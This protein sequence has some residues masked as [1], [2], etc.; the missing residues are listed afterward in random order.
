VIHDRAFFDAIPD[1]VAKR[2]HEIVPHGRYLEILSSCDLAILPL[3]DTSFNR[4]KSDLKFI[5]SCACG[6][7]PLCSPVVYADTPKHREIG[8]F[9]ES[10]QD[11][12]SALLDLCHYPE[13]LE[14][15]RSKALDYVSR[16]RM[17]G[18]Q[19][20]ERYYYYKSLLANQ[21]MLEAGRQDRIKHCK[22]PT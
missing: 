17:H 13:A 12:A 2:F 19:V 9:A 8:I 1:N 3:E 16:E 15:R 14:L 10:P 6:V 21:V 11:W 22:K 7:V 5:E 4:L 20:E 18:H